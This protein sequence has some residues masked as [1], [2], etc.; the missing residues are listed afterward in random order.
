MS[1]NVPQVGF[2]EVIGDQLWIRPYVIRHSEGPGV[3][4]NG[5]TSALCADELPF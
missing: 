4:S 1:R 2:A 5:K 3:L